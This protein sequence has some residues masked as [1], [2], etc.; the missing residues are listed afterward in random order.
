LL[1][2]LLEVPSTE[3]S[4]AAWPE[5]EAQAQPPCGGSWQR[6]PGMVRHTFTH[7]H[8]E[9]GVLVAEVAAGEGIW[10]PVE[11]LGGEALP[12]V[13]M[14]VLEKALTASPRARAA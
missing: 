5:V 12:T 1:G 8:L 7:F 10:V 14:K 4:G 11:R 6:L 3:W 13:M 9:L 2:G